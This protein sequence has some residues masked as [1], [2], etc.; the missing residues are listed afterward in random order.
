[1]NAANAATLANLKTLRA[2]AVAAS[3][4]VSMASQD[5][6]T[7]DWMAARA[8][9]APVLAARDEEE[10]RIVAEGFGDDTAFE[11]AVLGRLG[12]RHTDSRSVTHSDL[13]RAVA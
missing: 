1:M 3:C 11:F 7:A 8:A 10:A 5:G 9:A 2:A 6:T 13:C 12:R 4:V